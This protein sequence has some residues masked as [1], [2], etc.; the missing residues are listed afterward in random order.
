MH[1]ASTLT[2]DL[3]GGDVEELEERHGRV[4]GLVSDQ[5]LKGVFRMDLCARHVSANVGYG[6]LLTRLSS[7]LTRLS[8]L[9][10]R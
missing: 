9:L 7:L 1:A 8:S 4:V 2:A 3:L 6:S 10:T 5:L